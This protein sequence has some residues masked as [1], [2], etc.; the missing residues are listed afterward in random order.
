MIW[1]IYHNLP[2]RDVVQDLYTVQ[3]AIKVMQIQHPC[4]R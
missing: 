2:L 4:Y 1:I 3:V